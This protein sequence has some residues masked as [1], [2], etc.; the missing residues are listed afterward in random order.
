MYEAMSR[1]SRPRP[2]LRPLPPS[3]AGDDISR[4]ARTAREAVQWLYYAYLGAVK[5]QD[6]AAMSLGRV[7]A[8]L[9]SYIEKDLAA[10]TLTEEGAQELINQVRVVV[11]C[12]GGGEGEGRVWARIFG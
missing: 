9:D 5:E 6:G 2:R 10:G 11:V 4:P 1:R 12:G 7:D 8:F 3:P